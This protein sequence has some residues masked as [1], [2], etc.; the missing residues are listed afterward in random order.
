[1]KSLCN[2]HCKEN[3]GLIY[4]RSEVIMRIG[5][6]RSA[7]LRDLGTSGSPP[8]LEMVNYSSSLPLDG[9]SDATGSS[10][11]IG[12]EQ[13]GH[14]TLP[15]TSAIESWT[16]S[17]QNGKCTQ[18]T[19]GSPDEIGRLRGVRIRGAGIAAISWRRTYSASH[20]MIGPVRFFYTSPFVLLCHSERSDGTHTSFVSSKTEEIAH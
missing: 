10:E 15:P 17:W 3:L 9:P 16:K 8:G 7:S 6:T 14:G 20:N 2:R 4:R 13:F 18:D 19:I 12:R 5:A 11:L 1:M